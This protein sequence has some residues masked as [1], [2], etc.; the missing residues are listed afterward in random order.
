MI[1]TIRSSQG[2]AETRATPRPRLPAAGWIVLALACA[3][4]VWWLVPTRQPRP[5][6]PAAEEE[7]AA[8]A[9]SPRDLVAERMREVLEMGR[10]PG[11]NAGRLIAAFGAW[12]GDPAAVI[13]RRMVFDALLGQ[14]D[15]MARVASML[16]AVD[17]VRIPVDEDP[18]WTPTVEALAQV[19]DSGNIATGMD[20]MV[21]EERPRARALLIAS[22][23]K[24]A[25]SERAATLNEA[26][27]L[28]VVSDFIDIKLK[29]TPEMREEID[30]VIRH[31]QPS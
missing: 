10:A 31:L 4:G 19:W 5:G 15:G 16:Q 14:P 8:V 22:I 23:G 6:A 26:Q 9:A 3:A 11:P 2:Q 28:A 18:L 1:R 30:A 24:M 25:M 13:P 20:M 27:R 29:A 7:L 12:A 21:S 17:G